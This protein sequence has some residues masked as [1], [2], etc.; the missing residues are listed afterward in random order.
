[1][2]IR[3]SFSEE[4]LEFGCQSCP[5]H[6]PFCGLMKD[7]RS[8]ICKNVTVELDE[9]SKREVCRKLFLGGVNQGFLE[10]NVRCSLTPGNLP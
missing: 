8:N 1:M 4:V 10:L 2:D 7:E 3:P 9:I 6:G 5:D